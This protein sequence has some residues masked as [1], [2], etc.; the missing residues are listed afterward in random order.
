MSNES[1]SFSVNDP[2]DFAIV[3]PMRLALRELQGLAGNPRFWI[4]LVTVLLAVAIVG[5]FG[6]AG[7]M[8]L[9]ERA[10]YWLVTGT[11][12][13]TVGLVASVVVGAWLYQRGMPEWGSRLAG[14]AVAGLPI[15]LTVVA[16]NAVL[17]PVLR[18]SLPLHGSVLAGWVLTHVGVALAIATIYYVLDLEFR[19]AAA[20]DDT[21]G[22]PVGPVNEGS[23]S[24][25]D[26]LRSAAYEALLERLPPE[27]RGPVL[28]MSMQDHYVEVV[29]SRGSHLALMRMADAVAAA[30]GLGTRIHRSHW[31]A[32]EHVA[33]VRRTNGVARIVTSD[34]EELPVGRTYRAALEELDP[35]G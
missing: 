6:T 12:T 20:S 32:W 16:V 7:S 31:I 22:R 10:F 28:R 35:T 4:G 29:T 1:E 14:G 9:P 19:H 17:S 21:V 33:E 15:T 25:D 3:P 18:T 27:K 8:T 24:I 30:D 5:P 13:F 34:G 11:T 26:G 2:D 23:D